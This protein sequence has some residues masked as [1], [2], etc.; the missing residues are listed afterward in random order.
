VKLLRLLEAPDIYTQPVWPLI[1]QSPQRQ[2]RPRFELGAAD[3][4]VMIG[5][6]S[7]ELPLDQG[8]ILVLVHGAVMIAI[9]PAEF[10]GGNSEPTKLST[11]EFAGMMA[12]QMLERQFGS[13]LR[14][15]EVD[16]A[17]VITIYGREG[18]G[19]PAAARKRHSRRGYAACEHKYKQLPP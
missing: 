11:R 15:V 14:L 9:C 7:S 5:V 1:Q 18:A 6:G 4:A 3:R 12:I 8:E 16:G 13:A 2:S 19:P 17:I 10:L